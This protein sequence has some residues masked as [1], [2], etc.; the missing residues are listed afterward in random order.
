MFK[1]T[2]FTLMV[3]LGL[4]TFVGCS[5]SSDESPPIVVDGGDSNLDGDNTDGDNTDGGNGDSFIS[6]PS[7]WSLSNSLYSSDISKSLT[8]AGS[9]CVIKQELTGVSYSCGGL[10]N[11][12]GS[13]SYDEISAVVSPFLSSLSLN[14]S[15]EIIIA[16]S[17]STSEDF[18]FKYPP[19]IY[20]NKMYVTYGGVDS[21]PEI[22][23]DNASDLGFHMKH[24]VLE[25]NLSAFT[26]DMILE[27]LVEKKIY[28]NNTV[29][30]PFFGPVTSSIM[31]QNGYLYFNV[32]PD[33][34]GF[35][36]FTGYLY[37]NIKYSFKDKS[38]VYDYIGKPFIGEF[39]DAL[40]ITRSWMTPGSGTSIAFI[41]NERMT[42]IEACSGEDKR[43]YEGNIEAVEGWSL[44]S[45]KV[46]T[47]EPATL[48]NS[49]ISVSDTSSYYSIANTKLSSTTFNAQGKTTFGYRGADKTVDIFDDFVAKYGNAKSYETV[50]THEDT[51][52]ED[53]DIYFLGSGSYINSDEMSTF[54]LYLFKYNTN[55]ELQE[56]TLIVEGD[57]DAMVF[58]APEA[59]NL[60]KYK[61]NFY[62]K[63]QNYLTPE[64]YS[65]SNTNK[66]I[67]YTYSL[68]GQLR[69]YNGASI[70]YDTAI[71]G[72]TII[73]PQNI[74]SSDSDYDYDIVFTVLDIN[75]GAVL[76]TIKHEKLANVE[77]NDFA[78]RSGGVYIYANSVYFVMRKTKYGG[79]GKYLHEML[80]KLDSAGNKTQLIRHRGDNR[81][82]GVIRNTALESDFKP[83]TAKDNLI[84]N[85]YK[86]LNKDSTDIDDLNS[87]VIR[88]ISI[89]QNVTTAEL[90]NVVEDEVPS[91]EESNVTS[92]DANFSNLESYDQSTALFNPELYNPAAQTFYVPLLTEV[93]YSSSSEGDK[94]GEARIMINAQ[95]GCDKSYFRF[96][97]QGSVKILDVG[98]VADTEYENPPESL[99]FKTDVP[100]LHVDYS[101]LIT[102]MTSLRYGIDAK[103]FDSLDTLERLTTAV[104]STFD[105]IVSTA[106]SIVYGNYAAVACSTANLVTELAIDA[107]QDGD[108]YYGSAMKI[109][110]AQSNFGIDNNQSFEEDIIEGSAG[111]FTI[112]ADAAGAIVESVCAGVTLNPKDIISF[113]TKSDYAEK[114]V[115]AKVK[116][117]WHKGIVINN[118]NVNI[119]K[120]EVMQMPLAPLIFDRYEHKLDFKGQV[121]YLT[122]QSD[123]NN[124]TYGF[125]P[126]S[127]FN[128]ITKVDAFAFA[129]GISNLCTADFRTCDFPHM[130]YNSDFFA[131][132]DIVF[133]TSGVYLELTMYSDDIQFGV[134]SDTTFLDEALYTDT[135]T[136]VDKTYSKTI[137]KAFDFPGVGGAPWD[138]PVRG[139]ITYEVSFTVD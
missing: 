70:G 88:Y 76:K 63:Y 66:E 109:Y 18:Y 79:S 36:N 14:N 48:Y 81:Y 108:T 127:P 93:S 115:K 114:N 113:V 2:F 43:V 122:T 138:R 39:G 128:K 104:M 110:T 7:T 34:R 30:M 62:F 28:D 100:M 85:L 17:N 129:S 46:R 103:E 44:L 131:G 29:K 92:L 40:H 116:P 139:Y 13:F 84:A 35:E 134:F 1:N 96:P 75:T 59:K 21:N 132:E 64:F 6:S 136:K 105:T 72:D 73:I 77:A 133:S 32:Y 61:D 102:N 12:S 3:S 60:Y 117:T 112:D 125:A 101:T 10:L 118:M 56:A 31:E 45:T 78:Y 37:E 119:K 51:V 82:S 65:Y 87:S 91:Y 11:S 130:N 5:Q 15:P 54:D 50:F 135:F 124:L 52:F 95:Y 24:S 74:I 94:Y 83:Q 126:Y 98:N 16:E 137:R 19:L 120:L 22:S 121:G 33:Y 111:S 89:D 49:D 20:K 38:Y 41:E 55:L 25:Y 90:L 26:S 9:D 80:I 97:T 69:G 53:G 99:K 4:I 42:Q 47:A 107:I 8:L 58:F 68:K 23:E 67:N 57:T 71:T 123:G 86:F 106:I 27:S